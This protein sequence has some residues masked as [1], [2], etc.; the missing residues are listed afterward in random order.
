[1]QNDLRDDGALVYVDEPSWRKLES[2]CLIALTREKFAAGCEALANNPQ[3]LK[4]HM[5]EM[6]AQE[7]RSVKAALHLVAHKVRE[8]R[9]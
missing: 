5:G 6:T 3:E 2:P 1:M 9:I 4:L 7:M 8:G